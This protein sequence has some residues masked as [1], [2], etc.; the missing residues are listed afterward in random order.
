MLRQIA[1][2]RNETLFFLKH[3]PLWRTP[4]FAW[5]QLYRLAWGSKPPKTLCALTQLI[6]LPAGFI[7][8]VWIYLTKKP[9]T[10]TGPD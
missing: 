5:N 3:W 1:T 8:G 4:R 9:A 7:S 10:I 2:Y 6:Y